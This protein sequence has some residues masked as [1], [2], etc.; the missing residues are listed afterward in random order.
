M[1]QKKKPATVNALAE[2][3]K[4]ESLRLHIAGWSY[5]AIAA[6]LGYAGPAG[7]KHAVTSALADIPQERGAYRT[8]NLERLNTIIKVWWPRVLRRDK[9]AVDVIL[10]V[11]DR[12]RAILGL[13]YSADKVLPGEVPDH[14]IYVQE[15]GEIDVSKISTDDLEAMLAILE[16]TRIVGGE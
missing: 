4:S 8:V 6:K 11:I 3:R 5:R 14:P 16:A 9:E 2:I 13:D 12:Y 15:V 10:K 1:P 7:P